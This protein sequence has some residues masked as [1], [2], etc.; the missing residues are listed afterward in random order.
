MATLVN[1][2]AWHTA[3]GV[4][5][6]GRITAQRFNPDVCELLDNNG[7]RH[8]VASQAVLLTPEAALREVREIL[9]YWEDQASK[10]QKRL[11]K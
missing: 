10:L 4:L 9:A 2:E 1:R 8:S 5:R 7:T 6:H 11:E 3:S